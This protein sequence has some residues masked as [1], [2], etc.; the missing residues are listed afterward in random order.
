MP[1]QSV[2]EPATRQVLF[3][4]TEDEHAVLAALAYLEGVTPTE[5][6]KAAVLRQVADQSRSDR[7]QRLLRERREHE[8][9]VSGK[10]VS[11]NRKDEARGTEER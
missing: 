9:E 2:T 1:K 4:L 10:L 6:A 7:I 8:A 3:R 5:V 11:M